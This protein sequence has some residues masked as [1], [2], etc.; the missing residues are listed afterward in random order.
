MSIPSKRTI[1][2]VVLVGFFVL[3]FAMYVAAEAGSDPLT[4]I[5]LALIV[6]LMIAGILAG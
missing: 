2:I 4:G 5:L 3:G 1:R 6:A